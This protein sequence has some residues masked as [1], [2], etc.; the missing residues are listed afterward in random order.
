MPRFILNKNYLHVVL[1]FTFFFVGFHYR[2]FIMHP[3]QK[4]LPT[5][6]TFV[7]K[8]KKTEEK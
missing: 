6:P 7:T 3:S 5:H 4:A 8:K 1:I 2:E